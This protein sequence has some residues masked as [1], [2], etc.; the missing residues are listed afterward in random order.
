MG[1]TGSV[2]VRVFISYSS[3]DSDLVQPLKDGLAQAGV[4]VWVD[5]ERLAPGAPSWQTAIR[6]G[7]GQAAH[8]LYVASQTAA[9]SNYVFDEVTIA[10]NTGKL[11]IP[12]WVRGIDWHECAPIGWGLTQYIDA[13]GANYTVGVISVLQ[14]L[15][16]LPPIGR[17]PPVNSPQPLVR[18][19]RPAAFF[20]I[21]VFGASILA[22]IVCIF[23]DVLDFL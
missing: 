4:D 8:V 1:T 16:L 10:R 14:T 23:G 20:D 9:R 12:F 7:I 6:D 22:G 13:R 21:W 3:H 17:V 2:G 15:G 5:H 18:T 19:P 11:V